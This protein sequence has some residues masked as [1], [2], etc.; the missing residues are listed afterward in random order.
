[1]PR[2]REPDPSPQCAFRPAPSLGSRVDAGAEKLTDEHSGLE[3]TR[4][5][6]V[7]HALE[8]LPAEDEARPRALS[9]RRRAR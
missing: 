2:Q 3:Y 4:A 5:D 7:R 8:R 9:K 6:V 1:M